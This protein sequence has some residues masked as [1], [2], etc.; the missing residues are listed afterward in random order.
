MRTQDQPFKGTVYV[1]PSDSLLREFYVLFTMVPFK[2]SV[3][4]RYKNGVD[5]VGFCLENGII[6]CV[7]KNDQVWSLEIS[8]TVGWVDIGIKLQGP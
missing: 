7:Q 6:V 4:L 8:S 5:K 1:I 3:I 2:S